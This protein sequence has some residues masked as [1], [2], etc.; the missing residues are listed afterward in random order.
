MLVFKVF[1]NGKSLDDLDEFSSKI[2]QNHAAAIIEF[3]KSYEEKYN[4]IVHIHYA[5]DFSRLKKSLEFKKDKDGIGKE[6]IPVL[7][8]NGFG[9]Y[10]P[11]I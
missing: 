3:I 2:I 7:R 4:A 6:L 5:G 11:P 10:L 8:K 9:D 1:Y